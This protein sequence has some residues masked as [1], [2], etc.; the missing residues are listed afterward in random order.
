MPKL[1]DLRKQ[2]KAMEI[3]PS[4]IRACDTA[5]ELQ[6]V[7]NGFGGGN[8]DAPR[9]AKKS[10]VKKAAAKKAA[11][12]KSKVISKS[13]SSKSAPAAKSAKSGKAKRPTAVKTQ[14]KGTD[15]PSGRH[16]LDGVDFS[17]TDGW[18]PREGSAPDRIVKALKKFRGN[19]SK[20][21]DF[22]V[23]DVWD[24]VGKK[25]AD[26]SK[27]SKP[28]AEEMLRYRI[29]RTAFDFAVRT[30]QHEPSE[31][32]VQYGTGGTG[33][34]VWKPKKAATT[35]TKTASKSNSTKKASTKATARK[36]TG[37]KSKTTAKARNS[38]ASSKRKTA[39]R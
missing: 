28:D 19:R 18:N 11:A 33:D 35:K 16:L 20:V 13:A 23:D 39:K 15:G 17:D 9:A 30:G 36:N 4:L 24:F 2:A 6:A 29:S 26:G 14:A 8:G 5:E 31:N 34:G 1:A 38:K 27:R 21:F 3:A 25:K 37:R 22:L 10:A 32:R 12:K 7:I